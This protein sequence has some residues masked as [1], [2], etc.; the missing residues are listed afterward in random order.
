MA[1]FINALTTNLTAFLGKHIT[2]LFLAKHAKNR[3]GGVYRVWCAAAST[4]EEPYSI[5]MTFA[6]CF[7]G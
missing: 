7:W 1:E 5:A 6:R 3:A 2:F 4:G